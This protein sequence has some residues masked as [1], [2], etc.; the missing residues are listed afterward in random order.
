MYLISFYNNFVLS[1]TSDCYIKLKIKKMKQ[2][3]ILALIYLTYYFVCF[4]TKT[5]VIFKNFKK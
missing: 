1:L 2:I 4:T 5:C 3:L